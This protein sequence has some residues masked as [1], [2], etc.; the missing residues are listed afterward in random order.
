MQ[1]FD[2]SGVDTTAN[3]TVPFT[4]AS[5]NASASTLSVNTPNNLSGAWAAVMNQSYNGGSGNTTYRSGV[6]VTLP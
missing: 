6:N 4:A 5:A 2:L 3:G 1:T